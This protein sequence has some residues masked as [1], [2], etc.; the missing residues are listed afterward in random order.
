[1]QRIALKIPAGTTALRVEHVGQFSP[2]D[3]ARNACAVKGDFR[4]P[5]D[6]PTNLRRETDVLVRSLNHRT[7]GDTV[8]L[9]IRRDDQ[10]QTL[11]L[12]I[13]S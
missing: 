8:D 5:F 13:P 2:H 10:R 3:A 7:S 4:V 11:S 1:M 12:P 6:G 9:V